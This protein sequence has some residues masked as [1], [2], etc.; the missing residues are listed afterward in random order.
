M[1]QQSTAAGHRL[2]IR[3][4]QLEDIF[5][6]IDL[7]PVR[8]DTASGSLVITCAL[9]SNEAMRYWSQRRAMLEGMLGKMNIPFYLLKVGFEDGGDGIVIGL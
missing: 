5:F 3:G 6:C 4:E 8:V 7:G 9:E 2:G 1:R